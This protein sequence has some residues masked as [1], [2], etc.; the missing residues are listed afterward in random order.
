MKFCGT[1]LTYLLIT[2]ISVVFL[3]GGCGPSPDASYPSDQSLIDLFKANQGN[4]AKLQAD[5]DNK[6]LQS[7][8]KIK[9]VRKG[10]DSI[11]FDAWFY[12]SPPGGGM[13]GFLYS[14]KP[15]PQ[16]NLVDSIDKKTVPPVSPEERSL[17]RHIQGKWYL[18][19]YSVH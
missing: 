2:V 6:E 5:P 18:Y 9:R 10:F 15:I 12:A 8:L 3:V 17:Y 7:L 1:T 13:K 19:F 11:S 16:D 4:F 14:E